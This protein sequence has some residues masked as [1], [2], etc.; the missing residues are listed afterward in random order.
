MQVCEQCKS[1]KVQTKEWVELN[2]G[3]R[4]GTAS[5]ESSHF[6]KWCPVC[7]DH[8]LFVEKDK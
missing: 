7:E 3:K 1:D 5:E 6:D 4:M 2:S 8:V